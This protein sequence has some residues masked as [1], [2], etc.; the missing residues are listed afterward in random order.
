MPMI[1]VNPDA[2][3]AGEF[4]NW[5]AG[6]YELEIT[7][8]EQTVTKTGKDQLVLKLSPVDEVMDVDGNPLPKPGTLRDWVL[9]DPVQTKNG[10]TVSFLRAVVESAGL[11]WS[12]FNSDDLLNKNLRARVGISETGRNEILRYLKRK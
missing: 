4:P 12:N 2:R 5:R 10:G 6:E 3:S 8:I 9:I 7:E 1:T 11:E